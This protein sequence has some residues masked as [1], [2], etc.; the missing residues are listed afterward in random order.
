MEHALNKNPLNLCR[1]GFKEVK[2]IDCLEGAL[3][4]Y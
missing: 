3:A 4:E 2:E 1:V